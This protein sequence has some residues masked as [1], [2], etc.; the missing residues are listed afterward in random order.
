MKERVEQRPNIDKM[1]AELEAEVERKKEQ[2]PTTPTATVVFE[3]F[4]NLE[5][6]EYGHRV[7]KSLTQKIKKE[8]RYMHEEFGPIMGKVL[9]DINGGKPIAHDKGHDELSDAATIVGELGPGPYAL[10]KVAVMIGMGHELIEGWDER[11]K[12][13]LLD[14]A[15]SAA[16]NGEHESRN[17]SRRA[18]AYFGNTV[19]RRLDREESALITK[20]KA[21]QL[22]LRSSFAN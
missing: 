13:V 15:L 17:R 14:T 16:I 12:S 18:R 8:L 4:P 20:Y 7:D 19:H 11:G 2:R 1:I 5:T 9:K 3:L 21:A 6:W 10:L 22:K